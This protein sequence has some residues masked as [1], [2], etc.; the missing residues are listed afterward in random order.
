VQDAIQY[1]RQQGVLTQSPVIHGVMAVSV[2]ICQGQVMVD[3]CA[4]EDNH[5][6]VDMNIV[7]THQGDLIEI[8][9]TAEG[10][11]F[12]LGQLQELVSLAQR[13]GEAI[14]TRQEE[15]LRADT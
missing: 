9:G 1:L 11:P 4:P 6:S 14:K 10:S 13:A 7:L 12:S 8:Q 5:A 15:C 2:G 3:L